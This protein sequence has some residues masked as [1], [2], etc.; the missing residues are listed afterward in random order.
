[1]NRLALRGANLSKSRLGSI[2]VAKSHRKQAFPPFSE[3]FAGNAVLHAPQYPRG[4][5]AAS[6][7]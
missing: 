4:A 5:K 7:T 3:L 1:M 2:F 6:I